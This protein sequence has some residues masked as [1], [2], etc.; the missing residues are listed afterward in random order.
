ME[1]KF[2]AV[3]E[4]GIFKACWA[5]GS[6]DANNTHKSGKRNMIPRTVKITYGTTFSVL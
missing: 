4:L 3:K 5:C 1:V 2:S 6:I